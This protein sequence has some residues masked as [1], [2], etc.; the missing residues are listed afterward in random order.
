M[1]SLE[2][3]LSNINIYTLSTVSVTNMLTL[4]GATLARG[5]DNVNSF[6]DSIALFQL[7]A[8]D[9]GPPPTTP[10][11]LSTATSAP[12]ATA[13]PGG[14]KYE[15]CWRDNVSG[16]ALSTGIQVPG[17]A[18]AMTVEACTAGCRGAGFALAG[19][20]YGGECCE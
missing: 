5:A 6:Q 9:G 1:F 4:N 15:G 19:V 12:T 18:G 3:A 16:R 2:G 13:A 14:W 20:E 17:G 11:T 7:S 10:T 8:A